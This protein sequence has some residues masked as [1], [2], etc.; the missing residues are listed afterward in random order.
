MN[1]I[2]IPYPEMQSAFL[3]ILLKHGL[4]RVDAEKCAG[5]FSLN[6]LEGIYSHGV[7]R[8][9]RFIHYIR[10]GYIDVNANPDF[11][12][13]FNTPEHKVKVSFGNTEVF[14]NFGFNLAWRWS[15]TDYW[16]ATFGD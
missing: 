3:Q 4:S 1:T 7:Y 11:R 12:T 6:S 15:D 5:I 9:P 10:K 8:F 13:S 14:K 2:R 16:Q